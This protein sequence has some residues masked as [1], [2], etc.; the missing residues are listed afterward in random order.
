MKRCGSRERPGD[1]RRG[2]ANKQLSRLLKKA[3]SCFDKL[4][5]NGKTSMI[6]TPDPFVQLVEGRKKG[7]SAT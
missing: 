4:S 5:T 2:R 7:F 1:K 3:R 6:S